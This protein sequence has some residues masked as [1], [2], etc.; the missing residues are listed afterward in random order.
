MVSVKEI[1]GSNKPV[2]HKVKKFLGKPHDKVDCVQLVAEWHEMSRFATLAKLVCKHKDKEFIDTPVDGTVILWKM[3]EGYFHVGVYISKDLM[4]HSEEFR[5][6]CI[7]DIS[8][9]PWKS[10]YREYFSFDKGVGNV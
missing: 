4:I 9:P 6:V 8:Q 2:L 10:T 5:G 7:T 1:D 3:L